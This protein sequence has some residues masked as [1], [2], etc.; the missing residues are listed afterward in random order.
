VPAERATSLTRA[1]ATQIK[2][3]RRPRERRFVQRFVIEGVRQAREAL[4]AELGIHRAVLSPRLEAVEGGSEVARRLKERG[5]PWAEVS[6]RELSGLSDTE[7]PQGVLLVAQEPWRDLPG[8]NPAR[9]L[10][11]LDGVQDPGNVGTLIRSAHAFA[12]DGVIAL[13]GTA[14]PWGAKAVRASAGSV[15]ATP[16]V[17]AVV[18]EFAAWLAAR[19]WPRDGLWLADAGGEAHPAPLEPWALVVG[20]EGAGVSADLAQVLPQARRAAVVM[21]GRAESLNAGVAGSILMYSFTS[22]RTRGSR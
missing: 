17:R 19:E 20:N 2:K 16:V 7:A 18:A 14:D 6:D 15:F 11:V 12:L 1:E 10:L 3:L 8:L 22:G 4:D 5:V 21:P 13:T 9:R